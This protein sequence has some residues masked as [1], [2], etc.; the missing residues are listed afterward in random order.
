MCGLERFSISPQPWSVCT[1]DCVQTRAV[2]CL[3]NRDSVVN[4]DSCGEAFHEL[5]HYREC[6]GGQCGTKD[7]HEPE[8]SVEVEKKQKQN[9]QP[10]KKKAAPTSA[11]TMVSRINSLI[12]LSYR[13]ACMG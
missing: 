3:N 2:L 9:L 13:G 8:A 10:K 4:E 6:T 1:T 7:E 12:Q 5:Q 11:P